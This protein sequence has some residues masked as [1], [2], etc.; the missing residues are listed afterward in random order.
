MK[1]FLCIALFL[2]LLSGCTTGNQPTPPIQP[3]P[4]KEPSPRAEP[5][6]SVQPSPAS[7]PSA[8]LPPLLIQQYKNSDYHFEFIYADDFKLITP[9]YTNLSKKIVQVELPATAFPNTNFSD[10]GFAVSAATADSLE[11]CLSMDP[12]EGSKGFKD[13]KTINNIKFYKAEGQ[14]V[15]AGN[16]YTTR[17]YRTLHGPWCFEINEVVHT[18]NIANFE[19]GTVT[20]LPENLAWERL[21]WIL[22][23]FKFNS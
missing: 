17:S 20:A 16:I 19:P 8:P 12:P 9:H 1:K 7:E 15:G 22:S 11:K 14:G 6:P 23:N 3:P 18:R 2:I 13:T 5:L 21:E 10:A 4:M